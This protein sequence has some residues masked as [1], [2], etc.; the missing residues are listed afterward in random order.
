[1]HLDYSDCKCKKKKVDPLLIKECT[2]DIDETELATKTSNESECRCSLCT[3]YKVLFSVFSVIST[4]TSIYFV[5]HKYV[6]CKKIQFT[7]LN[8]LINGKSH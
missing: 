4:V 7:L 8:K 1:M 3:V 6:D 2:K 5:Y